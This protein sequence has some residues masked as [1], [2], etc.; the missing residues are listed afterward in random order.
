MRAGVV[1]ILGE[2]FDRQVLNL[3]PSKLLVHGSPDARG[4][5]SDKS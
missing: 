2:S 3:Q 4:A 5:F 1:R